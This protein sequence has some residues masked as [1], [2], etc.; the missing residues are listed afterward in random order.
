MVESVAQH[1]QQRPAH[2]LA[3]VPLAGA[4][5]RGGVGAGP[6]PLDRGQQRP[7]V[8]DRL[9]LAGRE[10]VGARDAPGKIGRLPEL[11]PH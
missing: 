1:G 6:Q 4:Q 8:G 10:G 3:L 5:E 7:P 11:L 2:L 9:A